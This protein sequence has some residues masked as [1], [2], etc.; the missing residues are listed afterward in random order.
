VLGAYV[1]EFIAVTLAE[2]L[3]VTLAGFI[4][5]IIAEFIAVTI[6]GES[7]CL[8]ATHFNPNKRG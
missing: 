3:A 1:A 6:A 8:Q 4:A 2:F 7:P 5:V